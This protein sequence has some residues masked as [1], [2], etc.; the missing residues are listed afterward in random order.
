MRHPGSGAGVYLCPARQAG[1]KSGSVPVYEI[2]VRLPCCFLW[3]K[4]RQKCY[5]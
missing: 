1:V 3:G 2:W 4:T 5:F